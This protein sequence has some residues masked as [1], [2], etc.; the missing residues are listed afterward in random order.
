[1]KNARRG[2][3]QFS[4][5]ADEEAAV[6]EAV[7]QARDVV[8]H[9]AS[10]SIGA[11]RRRE[12]GGPPRRGAPR[13]AVHWRRGQLLLG[14]GALTHLPHPRRL[15]SPPLR[16]IARRARREAG[17]GPSQLRGARVDAARSSVGQRGALLL[18]PLG[19]APGPPLPPHPQDPPHLPRPYSLRRT[20]PPLRIRVRPSPSPKQ[21]LELEVLCDPEL[22]NSVLYPPKGRPY[23]CH[24]QSVLL[25]T[26]H[27]NK[28]K[29]VLELE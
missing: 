14:A 16:R 1:M 18:R 26:I 3:A 25:Q 8:Q 13:R 15:L 9:L 28:H 2:T 24:P 10:G 29:T 11:W 19:A 17:G 7:T 27:D 21:E 23:G 12:G 22:E 6:K 20:T 5:A 4:E